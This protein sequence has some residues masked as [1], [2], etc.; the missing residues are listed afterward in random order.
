MAAVQVDAVEADVDR[1][2]GRA[3]ERRDDVLDV[4][5]VIASV[6]SWTHEVYDSGY[7]VV[8]SGPHSPDGR[9]G[10]TAGDL[11]HTRPT[12]GRRA[13]AAE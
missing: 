8:P 7:D 4:L 5:L 1:V 12:A 9:I 3:G 2:A 10:L 13:T 11:A 6:G